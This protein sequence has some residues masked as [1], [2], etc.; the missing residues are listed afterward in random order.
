MQQILSQ[1]YIM[2]SNIIIVLEILLSFDS[3]QCQ[4]N[5]GIEVDLIDMNYSES[6]FPVPEID[7]IIATEVQT[8]YEFCLNKTIETI[9]CNQCIHTNQKPTDIKNETFCCFYFKL[10]DCS[11]DRLFRLINCTESVEEIDCQNR[12]DY[13]NLKQIES[14]AI[15]S[16]QEFQC[17]GYSLDK[18]AQGKF[19]QILGFYEFLINIL[20]N[21]SYLR[22]IFG[23][24]IAKYFIH[25]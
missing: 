19:V 17:I 23:N 15:K 8:N 14:K 7:S 6:L 16:V 18:C 10:I 12:T 25:N 20:L 22:H 1:N 24:C 5:D 9:N 2:L 21:N 11:F 4:T 3:S 13:L